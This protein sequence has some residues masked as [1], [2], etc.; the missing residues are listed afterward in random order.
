[1]A[2]GCDCLA[3]IRGGGSEDSSV[4]DCSDHPKMLDGPG[5]LT[6]VMEMLAERRSEI[7]EERTRRVHRLAQRSVSKLEH[8]AEQHQA[9]DVC[10][11]CQQRSAQ[12]GSA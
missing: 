9:I 11:G 8:V 10:D 7:L 1:M 5:V 3:D 2:V 4:P 12:L 6:D